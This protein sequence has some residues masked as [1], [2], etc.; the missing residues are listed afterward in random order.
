MTAPMDDFYAATNDDFYD[1]PPAAAG[2][3]LIDMAAGAPAPAAAPAAI[4]PPPAMGFAEFEDGPAPPDPYGAPPPLPSG[5]RSAPPPPPDYSSPDPTGADYMPGET[6]KS[7]LVDHDSLAIPEEEGEEKPKAKCWQ[8]AFYQPWFNVDT[9]DVLKRAVRSLWPFSPTFYEFIAPGPDLWGPFWIATTMI[10]LMAATGNSATFLSYFL[11]HNG[12]AWEYDFK[13]VTFGAAAIYGYLLIIPLILWG[14]MKWRL[15]PIRLV[16]VMCCYGYSMSIY[17][18]ITI[19][20]I[21]PSQIVQWIVIMAACGVSTA[22]LLVQ[23]AAVFKTYWKVGMLMLIPIAV[24]SVGL[25]LTF[26]LYFFEYV[27]YTPPA[28]SSHTNSTRVDFGFSY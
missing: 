27:K 10:F 25:G 21:V 22:F 20:C 15:V 12:G 28:S 4:A 2:G 8:A 24:F 19:I 11:H 17:L 1:N 3:P 9:A 18:P 7:S 14:I 6:G 23:H 13:K 26:K 5:R 16:S